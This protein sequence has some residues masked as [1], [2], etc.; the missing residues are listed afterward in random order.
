M[1]QKSQPQTQ[2]MVSKSLLNKRTGNFTFD[3]KGLKI[4]DEDWLLHSNEYNGN[5]KPDKTYSGNNYLGGYSDHL[6]IY[7]NIK[8]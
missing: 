3:Q 4:F 2:M 5:K 8:K 6:P 7:I 1:N